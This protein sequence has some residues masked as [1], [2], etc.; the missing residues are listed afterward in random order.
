MRPEP[1]LTKVCLGRAA[2]QPVSDKA[3]ALH[4]DAAGGR[5]GSAKK[6]LSS[7][8]A[9]LQNMKFAICILF[10]GRKKT[11]ELHTYGPQL[12]KVPMMAES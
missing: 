1:Q 3:D 5:N 7:V 6:P 2:L 9:E 8:E 10:I 11:S 4:A 12:P